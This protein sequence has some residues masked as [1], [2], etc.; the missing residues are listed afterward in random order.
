MS[1][2]FRSD[3]NYLANGK[4]VAAGEDA[5]ILF[6]QVL[7]VN[8]RGARDG[9][10][11]PQES[12]PRFL[13]MNMRGNWGWDDARCQAAFDACMRTR[14]IAL[15]EEDGRLEIVGWTDEWRP[16]NP[17]KT[18]TERSRSL[19]QRRKD[20]EEEKLR[21][22]GGAAAEPLR[23]NEDRNASATQPALH[24]PLRCNADATDG[25]LHGNADSNGNG[26]GRNGPRSSVRPFVRSSVRPPPTR[27]R[28]GERTHETPATI[29]AID[30]ALV[31]AGV[32]SAAARERSLAALLQFDDPRDTLDRVAAHCR[33]RNER[34]PGALLATVLADPVSIQAA[35][36]DRDQGRAAMN[37]DETQ[38]TL[39]AQRHL[40]A[41]AEWEARF[42][43]KPPGPRAG[44]QKVEQWQ[45]DCERV[46][47]ELAAQGQVPPELPQ[48]AP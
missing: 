26:N 16:T 10:L 1:N 35:L 45:A 18:S 15:R 31:R 19:R 14:L 6:W 44:R 27:G 43:P 41:V 37:P 23:G 28:A 21:Q 12:T 32:G 34:N 8:H 17:P 24:G 7:G 3:E 39:R 25:P 2:W 48:E 36:V 30:Q 29:A 13:G 5:A 47:Q 42:L 40:D 46:R 9:I 33:G 38:K 4:V 22:A 20:A 11:E